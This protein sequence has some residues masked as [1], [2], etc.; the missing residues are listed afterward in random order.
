MTPRNISRLA[1]CSLALTA[2]TAGAASALEWPGYRGPEGNGITSEKIATKWPADGPKVVWSVP[3][4]EAFGSFAVGGGKVCCFV[5]VDDGE[6]CVSLDPNTG[7]QLWSTRI[8][9]TIKDRQGGDGPRST[10]FVDGDKVYVMGTYMKLACLNGADGK[11][12]WSHDLV[13]EFGG[14]VLH[15]GNASSPI[16]EGDLVIVDGGGPGQAIIA[17]NKEDGKVV[18]KELDDKPTHATATP[19]SI[20]GVKQLIFFMQSGLVSIDPPTGKVLWRQAFPYST[21]TAA[22][23][24]V[25]GNVVYCSAGYGSGAGAFRVTKEGDKF[26]TTQLWR[27]KTKDVMNHWSTPVVKDGCLYGLF[28]FQQTTNAPLKC[29][30]LETGKERWSKEGFGQGEVELVNGVLLV[31]AAAGQLLLVEATPDGYH[32]VSMAHPLGSKCWTAPAV[33]DGRIYA[34]SNK[35]GVCLDVAA[36]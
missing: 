22:S 29:I 16:V 9:K 33:A 30:D 2:L 17:F 14:S 31:Q 19:A 15:W 32:A 23:P 25:S 18:W 1:A 35:Q 24:V 26:T 34:R 21:S 7:K 5:K 8:D 6:A 27:E 20:D 3:L 36:K 10:P 4:G 12:L 13:S 11:I 28:G